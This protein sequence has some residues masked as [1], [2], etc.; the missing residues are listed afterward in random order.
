METHNQ[1]RLVNWRSGRGEY[2][3]GG[4]SWL[5]VNMSKSGNKGYICPF[6][7]EFGSGI[8][9]QTY[10]FKGDTMNKRLYSLI[11]LSALFLASCG[12]AGASTNLDV[13]FT[14]FAFTPNT[15]TIPA[16]QEITL[17]IK[18]NGAV[19]HEF[20]IMNLGETV[21]EDFGNEDEGNIYWEVEAEIGES[22][23]VTFT[24]P[25][26]PGV[27]EVV[28]GTPGHYTSGMVGSLTVVAGN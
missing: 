1:V 4:I 27:Y 17:N 19:I 7:S 8:V 13:V 26:E 15:F 24:A 11:L 10:Q 20:V 2:I 12:G 14:E 5:Q 25:S 21:G 9:N 22:K 3:D 16:G 23:T 28:C 6:V 18:N